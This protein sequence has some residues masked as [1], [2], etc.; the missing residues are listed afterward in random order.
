M[1]RGGKGLGGPVPLRN[2]SLYKKPIRFKR[3]VQNTN[4]YRD[5][6]AYALMRAGNKCENCGGEI[7][8]LSPKGNKIKQ[9]DMHHIVPFDEIIEKYNI[10]NLQQAIMCPL[11]WDV[12][13][14]KI[15]CHDCHYE[16]DESYGTGKRK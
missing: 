2:K 5:Q 10:T 4:Q 7:G 16:E 14:V 12:N 9:F 1:G 11:L 15:L 3:Q 13:N 8:G 6:R